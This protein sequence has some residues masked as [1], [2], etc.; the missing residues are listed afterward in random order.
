MFPNLQLRLE[1][2]VSIGKLHAARSVKDEINDSDEE[3]TLA[4]WCR[5]Q[6]GFY[7]VEDESIQQEVRGLLQAYQDPQKRRGIRG[8]DPFVIALASVKGSG[9][10][11]VSSERPSNGNAHSNPNIPFVCSKRNI[12]HLSFF[13][14]LKELGWRF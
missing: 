11:V 8:A 3:R 10:R 9:W 5:R 4:K 7:V 6:T 13:E 1:E 14:M 12:V 2:L